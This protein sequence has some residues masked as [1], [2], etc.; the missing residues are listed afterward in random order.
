MV[1]AKKREEGEGNG[2]F[3]TPH[4]YYPRPL[5]A[6]SRYWDYLSFGDSQLPDTDEPGSNHLWHSFRI[7]HHMY[8]RWE[9]LKSGSDEIKLDPE[10]NLEDRYIPKPPPPKKPGS[11]PGR[12][13]KVRA[14][15]AISAP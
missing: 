11:S 5:P 2:Y 12:S 15:D 8:K 9:A 7:I 4:P 6:L 3:N 13:G 14:E 1:D 10:K